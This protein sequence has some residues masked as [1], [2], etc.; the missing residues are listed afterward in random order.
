MGRAICPAHSVLLPCRFWPGSAP[1][2]APAEAPPPSACHC[3]PVHGGP[4]EEA[5]KQQELANLK[6]EVAKKSEQLAYQREEQ[7]RLK[8]GLP[9]TNNQN[10]LPNQQQA[11]HLQTGQVQLDDGKND[12]KKRREQERLLRKQAILEKKKEKEEKKRWSAH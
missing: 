2:L 4:A 5:K 7:E 6:N 10:V 12:P 1:V 11:V 8:K 3:E 9:L